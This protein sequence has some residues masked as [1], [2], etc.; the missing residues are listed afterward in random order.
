ME[1]E[2]E[3]EAV[4]GCLF[5]AG[6]GCLKSWRQPC[7]CRYPVGSSKRKSGQTVTVSC[8]RYDSQK[9]Q[10]NGSPSLSC[11]HGTSSGKQKRFHLPKPSSDRRHGMGFQYTNLPRSVLVCL[12]RKYKSRLLFYSPGIILYNA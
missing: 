8:V 3:V 1:A 6:Q 7:A 10:K 9:R 5:L 4:E 2:V 11:F 12:A